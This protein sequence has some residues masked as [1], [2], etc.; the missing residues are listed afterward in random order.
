MSEDVATK[1]NVSRARN[2]PAS[3]QGPSRLRGYAQECAKS[4]SHSDPS[5]SEISLTLSSFLFCAEYT[6]VN[7][8]CCYG[9]VSPCG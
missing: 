1:Y 7:D 8:L 5:K 6:K 2:C 9:G 3:S 4:L